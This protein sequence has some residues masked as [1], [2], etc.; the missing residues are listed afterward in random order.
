MGNLGA[1]GLPSALPGTGTMC[2][3]LTNEK[4]HGSQDYIP[5]LVWRGVVMCRCVA[6]GGEA[7]RKKDFSGSRELKLALQ[8][9]CE[10]SQKE[11][12]GGFDV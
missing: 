7:G 10:A 11:T 8:K 3:V 4:Q 12:Y 9:Q 5:S 6:V 1:V 2:H